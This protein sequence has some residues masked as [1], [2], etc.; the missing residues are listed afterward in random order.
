MIDSFL[1]GN[2]A[3]ATAMELPM[4]KQFQSYQ[5]LWQ[6]ALRDIFSIAMDEDPDEPAQLDITLPPILLDDL[7]KIGQ[8]ISAVAVVFPEI[9]V[10][11]VLRSLLSSLNVANIDEVMDEVENKQ[12]EL[13]LMDQQNKAH[14]LKLAAAK[15]AGNDP[16]DPDLNQ[17]DPAAPAV[18][19]GNA[20][21]DNGDL[22]Y[23]STESARQTKA[24]NRLAKVLEE[25]SR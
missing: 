7:R 10:P 12:G 15:S 4:L 22:G 5:A 1:A 14:Q 19:G 17:A 11:A 23:G 21:P 8:F 20:A 13:A 18:P 16:S 24:L 3:T 25:A 6:D 2:L 9:R